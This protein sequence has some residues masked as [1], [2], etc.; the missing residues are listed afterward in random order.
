MSNYYMYDS[1]WTH[2]DRVQQSAATLCNQ[3]YAS[4]QLALRAQFAL[5]GQDNR[6]S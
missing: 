3:P 6:L 5:L 1:R 4:V 2:S